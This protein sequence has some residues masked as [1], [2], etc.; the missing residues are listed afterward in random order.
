MTLLTL[1]H[2]TRKFPCLSNWSKAKCN[3]ILQLHGTVHRLRHDMD[4]TTFYFDILLTA[5]E[6]IMPRLL[7]SHARR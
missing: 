4:N 3:W 7:A 1:P 2:K 5:H 6:R